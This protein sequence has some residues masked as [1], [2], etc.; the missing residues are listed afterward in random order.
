MVIKPLRF[1]VV[2]GYTIELDTDLN[3]ST[4][5]SMKNLTLDYWAV[6]VICA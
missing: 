1:I 6:Y 4:L 5:I 2:V 3:P